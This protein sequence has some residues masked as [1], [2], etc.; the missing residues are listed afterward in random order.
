MEDTTLHLNPEEKLIISLC[1][2]EFTKEQIARLNGLIKEI[3]DWDRFVTLSNN[4]G[5]VALLWYNLSDSDLTKSI[6]EKYVKTLR[7]A[8]L[9][10]LTFNAFLYDQLNEI[11]KLSNKAGIKI[12]IL[13]GL[14]LEK[15]IYGNKGIRQISDIDI[16]VRT[17][18]AL[19]LRHL[20]IEQGFDSKPLASPL[21]KKILPYLRSHLPALTKNGVSVEIHVNLFRERSNTVTDR[22][23]DTAYRISEDDIG[24][25]YPPTQLFFLYLIKHVDHHEKTRELQLKSYVDLYLLLKFFPD[26][27][28]NKDLFVLA[29]EVNLLEA[30]NEKLCLLEIFWDFVPPLWMKD[31]EAAVNRKI[32]ADEFI[33][34]IKN[35]VSYSRKDQSMT[36]FYPVKRIP[37]YINKIYYLTGYL[38]PSVQ[39]RKYTYSIKSGLLALSYYPV[40]WFELLRAVLKSRMKSENKSGEQFE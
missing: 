1:R 5:V 35:P 34:F 2:M 21:H 11:I 9:K 28:L 38:I 7:A 32:I 12:V 30:V 40:W 31:Y 39:Y 3:I 15:T 36:V 16:L 13:K 17:D 8:Y 24:V 27:I 29:E 20:L 33:T 26:E 19:A 37:G 10:S 25:Y 18:N 14:A 22:F 4:L 6:P 23:F